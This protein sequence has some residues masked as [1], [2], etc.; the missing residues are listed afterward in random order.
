MIL[1]GKQKG[2]GAM[3]DR[4]LL[5]SRLVENKQVT[6]EQLQMALERQRISGGRLGYNLIAL[7]FVDKDGLNDFLKRVPAVPSSIED[8]GLDLSFIVDLINKHVVFMGEVTIPQVAEM[9]KLPL[10]V[11]NEAMDALRRERLI[12]V[13]GATQMHKTSYRYA[14]TDTG[15]NR[16]AELLNTCRYVGPAPV[17]LDEYRKQIEVQTVMHVV[18]GPEEFKSAFSH[19]VVSESLL[20]SLG[21]AACSGRPI[22]IYGPPGNGKTTIAEAIGRALPGDVYIPHAL[23]VGGE[24]IT[25]FD[26]SVHEPVGPGQDTEEHDQRWMCVKRPTIMAGG[27]LTMRTL[28]LDFNPITKFYEAP[29]QLK[30]NNGLFVIDDLGRQQMNIETLLNRW[31]Y[32]MTTR[33]DMLTL[34]TGRKFE[35]P[36]DQLMIFSTNID[37][38]ELLDAAFL[39]RL[40]HK[41]KVDTPTPGEYRKVFIKACEYNNLEFNVQAFAYLMELYEQMDIPLSNCHPR[42]IVE[43]VI[44]DAFYHNH[45]PALTKEKIAAACNSLFIT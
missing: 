41:I 24:I 22:F 39:R 42:D 38:R 4:N 8:T 1:A 3:D 33:K 10:F 15:R 26:Q 2:S 14:M 40:R 29:L 32:P 30:S 20:D 5:G 19:L 45:K 28:D 36:F 35:I 37:P 27:E 25:V 17:T 12:E 23:Q 11:V 21:T 43:F 7:G 34:H 6:D 16:A 31:I 44:D 13:K 9:V 18:I